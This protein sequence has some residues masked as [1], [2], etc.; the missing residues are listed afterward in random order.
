[1]KNRIIS[2]I[3][4][5]AVLLTA[6]AD[7][8]N[9]P[10][11][12]SETELISTAEEV[13]T[14]A[15]ETAVQTAK[16]FDYDGLFSENKDGYFIAY[17]EDGGLK[18]LTED[19]YYTLTSA[20]FLNEMLTE[21]DFEQ[22][23]QVDEEFSEMSFEEYKQTIMQTLGISD[24]V[25]EESKSYSVI[26]SIYGYNESPD[27]E[28]ADQSFCARQVFG[29][30]TDKFF[31]NIE[32]LKESGS[33][34]RISVEYYQNNELLEIQA[35]YM[36]D[37]GIEW[38]TES[39]YISIDGDEVTVIGGK[40]I[41]DGTKSLYLSYYDEVWGQQTD[42]G[43]YCNYDFHVWELGDFYD[44]V[45][46]DCAVIAEGM[47][48][49]EKLY[50]GS[51]IRLENIAALSALE[52]LQEVQIENLSQEDMPAL[53]ELEVRK[54]ILCGFFASTDFLSD[55]AAKELSLI[56]WPLGDELES[57]SKLKNVTE[58]T[59]DCTMGLGSDW[60]LSGIADMKGLKKL[61]FIGERDEVADLGFLAGLENLEQLS[62]Y[63]AETEN[64]DKIS[65]LKQLKSL[66]LRSVTEKDLTFIKGLEGLEELTLIGVD[67]S[68][69]EALPTLSGLKR[70]TVNKG[71]LD[72]HLLEGLKKLEELSLIQCD[73]KNLSALGSCSGLKS[74]FI[75]IPE[76]PVFNAKDISKLNGLSKLRI[77][78]ATVYNTEYLKKLSELEELDMY[79]CYTPSYDAEALGKALPACSIM[80]DVLE[81]IGSG[82]AAIDINI[83][84]ALPDE[85]PE[86]EY[87]ETSCFG[88]MRVDYVKMQNDVYR[89]I[90][91]NLGDDIIASPVDILAE[92]GFFADCE[93]IYVSYPEDPDIP[94]F[95]PSETLRISGGIP[96][97]STAE[98]Y[99]PVLFGGDFDK[100]SNFRKLWPGE[101][102][103]VTCS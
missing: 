15:D 91:V 25:L 19:D 13:K 22:I 39:R 64:I 57:I 44:E 51:H 100:N 4:L 5:A 97:Y 42:Y 43:A 101:V 90:A 59:V 62:I 72:L 52:S 71:Q 2:I 46:L 54:L 75:C 34:T 14:S 35:G 33:Q 12:E 94:Y 1:M 6:C 49:L 58:L 73:Q 53:S 18:E 68:F 83:A 29:Y 67:D 77:V 56:I 74:L 61:E 66:S 81:T 87:L 9:T 99:L 76:N 7:S 27:G 10:A 92:N 98:I 48:Q 45:V 70:L 20:S 40:I 24:E 102:M 78:S 37:D 80:L 85:K 36:T 89:Y 47:P 84:S 21:E 63:A 65:S 16:T 69:A 41:P 28:G 50:I 103:Y 17:L 32:E 3:A 38:L 8:S 31:D 26:F 55:M 88:D 60:D 86:R 30:I 96:D 11:A 93:S 79:F 95:Q 23:K 82:N